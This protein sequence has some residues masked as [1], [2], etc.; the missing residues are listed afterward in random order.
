[1]ITKAKLSTGTEIINTD[2]KMQKY[3]PLFKAIEKY[4][5]K[6]YDELPPYEKEPYEKGAYNKYGAI[7]QCYYALCEHIEEKNLHV[8]TEKHFDDADFDGCI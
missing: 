2:N 4:F 6:R 7:E 5:N 8:I 1:M 3:G